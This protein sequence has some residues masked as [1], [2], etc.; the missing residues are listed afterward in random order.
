MGHGQAPGFCPVTLLVGSNLS[1]RPDTWPNSSCTLFESFKFK[2]ACTYMLG[3]IKAPNNFLETNEPTKLGHSLLFTFQKYI[4]KASFQQ[5][6]LPNAASKEE[7][8][9]IYTERCMAEYDQLL[10]RMRF[11]PT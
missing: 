5:R 3:L 9:I 11:V 8:N 6:K 1:Y 10:T 4:T 2:V 7:I